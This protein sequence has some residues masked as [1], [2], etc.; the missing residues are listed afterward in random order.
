MGNSLKRKKHASK[1]IPQQDGGYP[2]VQDPIIVQPG[3]GGQ[4]MQSATALGPVATLGPATAMPPP[5]TVVPGYA[6]SAVSDRSAVMR[7]PFGSIPPPMRLMG[8]GPNQIAY[9][10][11][12]LLS[13][14]TGWSL[15]DIERLRFEFAT[16]SNPM[17]VIDRE[18]FRRLFV[19][20]LLN[21]P[22]DAVDREA[23]IAFR[24]FDINRTGTLDFNE[25]ITACTRLIRASN[26][27][28]P[29]SSMY[30]PYVS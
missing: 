5:A 23:E 30:P 13:N 12:V 7:A 4:P 28:P 24:T 21:A 19:S 20:S 15:S 10:N 16:Y 6:A 11:N 26:G 9:E 14:L 22:W 3:V 27:S 2:M 17:G 29:P 8:T 25:Y 18:G 1:P